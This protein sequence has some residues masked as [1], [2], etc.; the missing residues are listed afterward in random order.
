MKSRSFTDYDIAR[1]NI[2]DGVISGLQ[3]GYPIENDRYRLELGDLQYSQ[4]PQ[5]TLQE[6]KDAVLRGSTLSWPL[7][8]VWKLWD[9]TTEKLVS[10]S[11]KKII[12][13]PWLTQRGTFIYRGNEYIVSNQNRLKPGVYTRIK[14]NGEIESHFNFMPGEGS[15]FRILADPETGVFRMQIGGALIPLYPLLKNLGIQDSDMQAAWGRAIH[16]ANARNV[17]ENAVNKAVVRLGRYRSTLGAGQVPKKGLAEILSSFRLDPEV[18]SITLGKPYTNVQPQTLLDASKRVLGVMR[19][20]QKPDDRDHLAF[21]RLYSVEDFFRERLERDAG[22]LGKRFLWRAT[23]KGTVK[24]I[25]AGALTPQL[26]GVLLSSGVGQS[27]EETNVVDMLD[28]QLRTTRLGEGGIGSSD[29]IPEESRWVHASQYGFVDPHRAPESEKVGVDTRLVWNVRKGENGRILTR[30]RNVRTGEN[31]WFSPEETL[32][33]TIAMANEMDEDQ[34]YVVAIKNEEL[35]YVPRSEVTHILPDPAYSNTATTNLIPFQG[36]TNSLRLL[37]AGKFFNQA[38]ALK[39]PEAPLVQVANPEEPGKSFENYYGRLLGAVTARES[40]IVRRITP[41]EIVVDTPS[42]PMKYE[43]YYNFPYNRKSYEHNYPLVRVGQR[44]YKG[45]VL[46]RSNYTTDDGTLALGVNLRVGFIPYRGYNHEDAIVISESA[47]NKLTSE[48]M[49]KSTVSDEEDLEV[50]KNRFISL[51]PGTYNKR[52]LSQIDRNGVIRPGSIVEKGDPIILATAERKPTGESLHQLYKRSNI[53]KSIVWEYDYP[54]EVTDVLSD[55]NNRHTVLIKAY[56]PTKEADKIVNRFGN[57]GLV[58]AVYPD[59]QMPRLPDGRH[60]EV[61]LNPTGVIGRGNPSQLIEMWLGKIA[62]KRGKPY[63]LP[64][65]L[66]NKSWL[67]FVRQELRLN[68]LT[69][70]E[71]LYDPQTGRKIHDVA[72]GNMF[73]MKL[74]HVAESKESGRSTDFY[75][76]EMLP[77][78]G[79]ATGSKKIGLLGL[80]AI[81]SHGACFADSVT[82]LT[83]GGPIRISEIVRR[84]MKVRAACMDSS[85]AIVF[86]EITNWFCREAEE[87]E[88]LLVTTSAKTGDTE[89][90]GILCTKGHEFYTP[91]GKKQ[92]AMLSVGDTVFTP[93]DSPECQRVKPVTITSISPYPTKKYKNR[94]VYDITVDEYHNYVANGIVVGNSEVLKDAKFIRGQRNDEYWKAFRMGYTPPMPEVP[95]VYHK[96]LG[97]L[98]GSGINVERRGNFLNIMALTDSD[99]RNMSRGAIHSDETLNYKTMK[100]VDGG[101]FDPKVTGGVGGNGWGHIELD[102]PMPNPVTEDIIKLFT[103]LTQNEFEGV[104]AGKRKLNGL[105]GGEA[106]REFLRNLNIRQEIDRARA[107]ISEGSAHKKDQAVKRLKYLV[108]FLNTGIRPEQLV[109]S[110]VPVLPPAFRPITV[111]RGMQFVS[112]ANL[113][114]Q[115]LLRANENL[116]AM[117]KI[118][119]PEQAYRERLNLYSAL[120]AVTGLGDPTNPKLKQKNIRGLL[121]HV[122]A[123]SPKYG[124]VQYKLMGS[125]VDLVGRSAITPNPTLDMDH[126]GLPENVAWKIYEPFIV[127]RLVRG[128]LEVRRAMEMVVERNPMAL[129]AL[130]EE[131]KIR[132]VIINRAPTL[133]KFGMMAALPIL[134]RSRTLQVP[135]ITIKGYGGDF[136]GD[137]VSVL[138]TKDLWIVDGKIEYDTIY[139]LSKRLIGD[140]PN[141]NMFYEL[142][143]DRLFVLSYK[144]GKAEFLPVSAI[145]FHTKHRECR[146]VVFSTGFSLKTTDDHGMMTLDE[147][148]FLVRTSPDELHTGSL[149]PLARKIDMPVVSKSI[150]IGNS[151]IAASREFGYILGHYLGDGGAY[152]SCK[153]IRLMSEDP[154]HQKNIVS[155][156]DALK[157]EVSPIIVKGKLRGYSIC[158]DSLREWVREEFGTASSVQRIPAWVYTTPEVFRLGVLDGILSSDVSVALRSG[159]LRNQPVMTIGL[160]NTNLVDDISVLCLSLGIGVTRTKLRTGARLNLR[161][162]TINDLHLSH[163]RRNELLRRAVIKYSGRTGS[164]TDIVPWS[165]EVRDAILCWINEGKH[166]HPIFAA[167]RVKKGYVSRTVFR[168][169]MRLYGDKVRACTADIV[170]RWL[171]YAE[172]PYIEWTTVSAVRKIPREDVM[173]DVTLPETHLVFYPVS[174]ALTHQTMN[175]HVPASEQ[176]RQEALDK[177]LP[178]RN[179]LSLT[180]FDVHY[181]PTQEFLLGLYQAT[182]GTKGPVLRYRSKQ[183]VI[184][185]FERGELSPEQLVDIP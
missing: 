168:D 35:K 57:K 74:S 153:E 43:L 101:L 61:L 176:A 84:R 179:L 131:M 173:F 115:E 1:S 52:Q 113:L 174:R 5:F 7:Q 120:K 91:D 27:P 38:L 29:A 68:G 71:D 25:P 32:G 45:D 109:W 56:T 152:D 44:V 167:T 100:P 63:I 150:V 164:H 69:D 66:P 4:Q 16:A 155:C 93:G 89:Y 17:D 137:S 60:L 151:E 135:P 112:D 48:H 145:H 18:T 147:H 162:D 24:D 114:Y 12:D 163:P 139:N 169:F 146:E 50:D 136:D 39:N 161:L 116:K 19:G 134:T 15:T 30:F 156:L 41:E 96:F 22:N 90:P 86:R 130:Q 23:L 87:E 106:I 73:I 103:N 58:A 97:Y 182:K 99:I 78:K 9:K 46:A 59:D 70:T 47:A 92:A 98:K 138:Y 185:A 34:P 42:G 180:D 11:K 108:M 143:K 157:L 64:G 125:S 62:E 126:V 33:K 128:G 117:K 79:G 160:C 170:T 184:N 14:S 80:N 154:E 13:V 51:F 94:L 77:A 133:H 37:L 148:M 110:A 127:R 122:L 31:E 82:V 40:G 118:V 88:L 81:L 95:F 129:E 144:C 83:D 119:T 165:K 177:M 53:D 171:E 28:Q 158:N 159:G 102:E 72:T 10:K 21:Q 8:G 141:V 183:D 65:Y 104:I 105:T 2:F 166:C 140:V 54:G 26:L 149:I 142:D 124:M 3:T 85:G 76:S 132:P 121:S 20:E 55:E 175:Y 111:F 181:V 67:D 75:T 172:S 6:Q 178:S 107:D 49:Y 36:A 123:G